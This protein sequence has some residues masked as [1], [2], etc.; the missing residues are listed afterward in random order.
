MNGLDW[1]EIIRVPLPGSLLAEA[2]FRLL[3]DKVFKLT[4]MVCV[5]WLSV[6]SGEHIEWSLYDAG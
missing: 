2:F 5:S 3:R 6:Q 1:N 4:I